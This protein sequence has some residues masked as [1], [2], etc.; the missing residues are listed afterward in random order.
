M[1]T[2]IFIP[3]LKKNEIEKTFQE[4]LEAG[5]I[6]P[7]TSPYSSHVVMVL[8]KEGTLCMCH[9][10]CV[11]NKLSIKKKFPIPIIDDLLDELSGAQY[12]TKLDLHS[13]YH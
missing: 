13:S 11:L 6:H 1:L 7:S 4:L 9:D 2:L 3:F 12:F 8:K 5:A 10:F